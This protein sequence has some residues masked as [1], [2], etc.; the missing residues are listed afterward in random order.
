MGAKVV[1]DKQLHTDQ[2]VG[3]GPFRRTRNPLYFGNLLM[4]LGLGI[5]VGALAC[6]TVTV[7][8]WILLTL[9]IQD[10]EAGLEEMQ[11][12]PYRAYRAAVPRMLPALRA[13]IPASGDQPHWAHGICGESF[14][15]VFVVATAGYAVTL[16]PAW[17]RLRLLW[18]TLV[19]VPLFMWARRDT[20]KQNRTG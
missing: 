1:Q 8:M 2:L 5:M 14:P 13:H 9:F 11:G 3:D 4:I 16:D 6:L 15:W 17:Y 20:T 7:G 19:A 10:E 18:G 12:E